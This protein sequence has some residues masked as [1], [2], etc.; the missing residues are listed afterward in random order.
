[1][2]RRT[3]EGRKKG[4]KERW[5]ERVDGKK[6]KVLALLLPYASNFLSPPQPAPLALDLFHSVVAVH[7]QCKCMV[8]GPNPTSVSI[9]E[10]TKASQV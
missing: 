7:P 1:M 2:E 4:R 5:K 6:G 8:P 9:K 10:L 3:K